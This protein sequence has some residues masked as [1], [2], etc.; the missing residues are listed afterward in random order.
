MV[1]YITVA[2][3]RRRLGVSKAKM[4]QIIREGRLATRPNSL[5]KRSLLVSIA[6]V[7]AIRLAGKPAGPK[8]RAA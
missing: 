2:E 1:D 3:A 6:E 8:A 4:A 7:E 5:D